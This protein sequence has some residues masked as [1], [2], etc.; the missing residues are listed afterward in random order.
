ME[1]ICGQC[2]RDCGSKMALGKHELKCIPFTSRF[3]GVDRCPICNNHNKSFY[4]LGDETLVCMECG[5]HFMPR[6]ALELRREE[7]SKIKWRR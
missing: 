6:G 7:L 5:V 1:Y 3:G 2:G 4:C